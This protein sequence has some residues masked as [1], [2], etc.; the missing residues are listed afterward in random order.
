MLVYEV[1][2]SLGAQQEGLSG[3]GEDDSCA[4]KEAAAVKSPLY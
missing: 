4:R 3:T 2:G 1:S